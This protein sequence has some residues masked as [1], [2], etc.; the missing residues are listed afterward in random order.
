MPLVGGFSRGCHVP[1]PLQSDATKF[2]HHF[3]PRWL[4]RPRCA[5]TWELLYARFEPDYSAH[6]K[7]LHPWKYSKQLVPDYSTHTAL[8]TTTRC[9]EEGRAAEKNT[10][11]LTRDCLQRVQ[12]IEPVPHGLWTHNA[13]RPGEEGAL[14]MNV[15][16]QYSSGKNLEIGW[17]IGPRLGTPRWVGGRLANYRPDFARRPPCRMTHA[18]QS[19]KLH[20]LFFSF[21]HRKTFLLL[22]SDLFSPRA[23]I[24]LRRR[25]ESFLSHDNSFLSTKEMAD[26]REIPEKTRRPEASSGTLPAC[27]NPGATAAWNRTRFGSVGDKRSNRCITATPKCTTAEGRIGSSN[28]ACNTRRIH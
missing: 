17:R 25:R 11:N 5:I 9:S 19:T 14:R 16:I 28:R 24:F 18:T 10:A 21:C 26:I 12:G 27:E 23:T 1:P 22:T 20:C 13:C 3:T 15:A 8:T 6:A 2:S 4:S 7:E